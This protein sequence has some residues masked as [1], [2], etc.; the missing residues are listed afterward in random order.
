M[1]VT[2]QGTWGEYN[3]TYSPDADSTEGSYLTMPSDYEG[4]DYTAGQ[5]INT[6]DWN[7]NKIKDFRDR[8]NASFRSSDV[9]KQFDQWS[10]DNLGGMSQYEF[11]LNGTGDQWADMVTSA[12]MNR[13]YQGYGV[14]EGDR[15]SAME[16]YNYYDGTEYDDAGNVSKVGEGI[17]QLS[18]IDP[19]GNY[20]DY[21]NV[22]GASAE[23]AAAFNK[24]FLEDKES[25]GN[26]QL[27][28][29]GKKSND[30]SPE[31]LALFNAQAFSGY[32]ANANAAGA[33]GDKPGDGAEVEGARDIYDSIARP[34]FTN[35]VQGPDFINRTLGTPYGERNIDPDLRPHDIY[36]LDDITKLGVEAGLMDVA[37]ATDERGDEQVFPTWVPTTGMASYV[38]RETGEIRNPAQDF[39]YTEG[40]L[41]NP[42]GEDFN[43]ASFDSALSLNGLQYAPY[44]ETKDGTNEFESLVEGGPWNAQEEVDRSE[45][46]TVINGIAMNTLDKEG[47]IPA[48]SFFD[49]LGSPITG[50]AIDTR[51]PETYTDEFLSK[52][53]ISGGLS[54]PMF[55]GWIPT[56]DLAEENNWTADDLRVYA[57]VANSEQQALGSNLTGAPP[58][59][60]DQDQAIDK[61]NQAREDRARGIYND[62]FSYAGTARNWFNP[63]SIGMFFNAQ[64]GRGEGRQQDK[65]VPNSSLYQDA[66][67]DPQMKMI[68][69]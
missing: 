51:I 8:T 28:L 23:A 31:D 24:G 15:D 66:K 54:G 49:Y 10:L 3:P 14:N 16:F 20:T 59:T 64:Q 13:F 25:I 12:D 34:E 47:N 42:Y 6:A 32:V 41:D 40:S 57:E 46:N 5:T 67:Y 30:V 58:S 69:E 11:Q 19:Y 36:S 53:M 52:D 22:V 9:T 65:T 68:G 17:N 29:D 56:K 38:D 26:G 50:G 45:P 48:D 63:Q 4:T 35:D 21:G 44:V 43:R 61:V 39:V 2:T 18:E 60:E 1:E 27:K 55:E 33:G 37:T 7:S 62:P